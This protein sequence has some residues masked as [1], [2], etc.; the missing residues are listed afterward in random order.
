MNKKFKLSAIILS[1][2]LTASI[3]GAATSS[4]INQEDSIDTN[5]ASDVFTVI[6]TSSTYTYNLNLDNN[7]NERDPLKIAL[8][9]TSGAMPANC[10]L[11]IGYEDSLSAN[12]ITIS[13]IDNLNYTI[14]A[15]GAVN[16]TI[17]IYMYNSSSTVVGKYSSASFSATHMNLN[18]P[19]EVILVDLLP[20]GILVIGIVLL[21][22]ILSKK[23]HI[24]VQKGLSDIVNELIKINNELFEK[25]KKETNEKKQKIILLKILAVDKTNIDAISQL[26]DQT[27]SEVSADA[28]MVLKKARVAQ[29]TIQAISKLPFNEQPISKQ[30]SLL[31]N[32]YKVVIID[33]KE[34]ID[35]FEKI[36]NDYLKYR[37]E[38]KSESRGSKNNLPI[39]ISFKSRKD[40]EK[41]LKQKNIIEDNNKDAED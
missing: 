40:Y 4:Y 38:I 9:V 36:W 30:F 16:T 8:S 41:Y 26:A 2:L 17:Y 11:N 19:W 39:Q 32:F 6:F 33:L 34:E 28:N 29:E 21:I 12:L 25:Y 13:K 23:K 3:A 22:I 35:Y 7:G 37:E 27:V 10:T 18:E 31:S 20:W 1:F 24:K 5:A 14:K 15:T